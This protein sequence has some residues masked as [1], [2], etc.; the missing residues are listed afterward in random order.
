[1]MDIMYI[2]KIREVAM[3]VANRTTRWDALTYPTSM[4]LTALE[5]L[6][7][8][9]GIIDAGNNLIPGTSYQDIMFTLCLYYSMKPSVK[10]TK[11]VY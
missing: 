7:F 6:F 4:P 1:M 2:G 10:F 5:A 11:K 8:R 3:Q 9:S